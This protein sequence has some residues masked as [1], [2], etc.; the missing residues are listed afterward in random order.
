[1]RYTKSCDGAAVN[2]TYDMGHTN[3][4]DF[5]ISVGGTNPDLRPPPPVGEPLCLSSSLLLTYS[6]NKRPLLSLPRDKQREGA[7]DALCQTSIAP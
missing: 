4:L 6:R 3:F 1:V 7:Y 5:A 2:G